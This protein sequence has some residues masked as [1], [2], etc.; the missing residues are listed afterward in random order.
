M[1]RTIV[2]T[3]LLIA[4]VVFL[5]LN[6]ALRVDPT[7]RNIEVFPDMAASVAYDS[8]AANPNFADGK[9]LREPV[10]G[11][12][13]RGH[14][15]LHYAATKEDAERAGREMTSPVRPALERGAAVYAAHCQTCHGPTGLGDGLVAKRGYPAPPSFLAPHAL[16]MPDGQMFHVITY[17]QANMPSYAAQVERDDRWHVIEYVR[18]LQ[19]VR[20]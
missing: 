10:P 18:K 11:T 8:Y 2:N 3:L 9:T 14:M 19:G 20:K 13:V 6:W 4:T 5:S 7:R 1:R 16:N 15:P 12:I 17:G